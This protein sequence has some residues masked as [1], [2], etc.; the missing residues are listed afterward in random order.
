MT[1]K[2]ILAALACAASALTLGATLAL[3]AAPAAAAGMPV[4]DATNYAQNLLQ[5][6]R[7]L[8]QINN[9]VKSLQN[10]ASM[11]QNMARNLA[12]IDFPQLRKIS[13]A[14]EQIDRLMSEAEGVRFKMEGLDRQVRTLFP[15]PLKQALT[16]D[17]RVL[18]ARAQLDAATAAYRQSIGVQAQVAENVR[19]DA[20]LLAE[21]AGASQSASGALQVGQAANQLIALS[22][23]QQLQLQN[24]MAAE[25]REAALERAR[26]VQAEE[27]GR[28]ATRRF[29][30]GPVPARN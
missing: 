12:T 23:K 19:A 20:G 11:L 27:D 21:L 29:L 6:A 18:A 26:R 13:L 15:G 5:A 17:Q 4:F 9:Q 30:D 2:L 7:A 28:A 25:F 14:M 10:E 24:L 16:G 3:P 1:M 22:I 8:D